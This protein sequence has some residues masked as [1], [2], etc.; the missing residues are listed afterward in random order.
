MN[1]DFESVWLGYAKHDCYNY[2]EEAHYGY[3]DKQVAEYFFNAGVAI[4]KRKP[5][6]VPALFKPKEKS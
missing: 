2:V 4:T 3:V 1:N 6:Q 5:E